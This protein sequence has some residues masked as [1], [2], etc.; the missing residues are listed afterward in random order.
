VATFILPSLIWMSTSAFDIE[1]LLSSTRLTRRRAWMRL[2]GDFVDCLSY[3]GARATV[4]LVDLLRSVA[5]VFGRLNVA[6]F[7]SFDLMRHC[8]LILTSAKMKLE[9]FQWPKVL[10][11]MLAFE[12]IDSLMFVST[13]AVE[14]KHC[15][16]GLTTIC[17]YFDDVCKRL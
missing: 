14:M 8:L 11:A 1:W 7:V 6:R 4:S 13:A 10:A 9:Q 16:R 17:V 5:I 15:H 3:L 12:S 2:L